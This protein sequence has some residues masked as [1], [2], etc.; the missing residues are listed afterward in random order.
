MIPPCAVGEVFLYCGGQ[1][2]RLGERSV[3]C[4]LTV[5]STPNGLIQTNN[6]YGC[7]QLFPHASSCSLRN[8]KNDAP[9][10]SVADSDTES[11]LNEKQASVHVTL[12]DGSVVEFSF[13]MCCLKV[14]DA[15][16]APLSA[17]PT[18][19]LESQGYFMRSN[20]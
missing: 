10:P 2:R 7:T 3:Q 17:A 5:C 19:L 12:S 20:T 8:M 9:E 18:K 1:F 4:A 14:D 6:G 16:S 13:L 11:W 15:R